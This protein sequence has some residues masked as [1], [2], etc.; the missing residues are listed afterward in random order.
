VLELT[1]RLLEAAQG[2]EPVVV[3]SVLEP[4]PLE[5][6][7]GSRLLVERDGRR[8]GTLGSAELDA[9]VAAHAEDMFT[10]HAAETLYVTESGLSER[11]VP[12][13]T[14]LYAE[15]IESKP[16]FVVIGAGHIGRSLSKLADFLDFH[17]VVI[18]DR[19]EFADPERLPEADQ[20][21]CQDYEEALDRLPVNANT[22]I[23]MVTRGHKQDEVA[24]R[25]AIGRGA[26]YVGMIGSR[27]RTSAVLQ[28]LAEDGF[29]P[30][31]LAR[32]RTPIG[33]DIG[34]ETPEEIAIAI[35]AEVVM[36]RR[37]GSAAPMY[38]R[39]GRSSGEPT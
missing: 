37:G 18:D 6:T 12:G 15:V 23:V 30:E 14:S 4:G 29:D 35:M 26:A 2:G 21:I 27:R 5:L 32:V 31:E 36:L 9:L 3:V 7:P 39:R 19:E 11:T 10:R 38:W 22:S 1:Q 17:V 16:A 34:A 20:V 28:H 13:A 24:L 8:L 25:H 33:L